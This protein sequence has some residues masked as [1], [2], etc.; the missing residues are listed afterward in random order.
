[1]K[2]RLEKKNRV[3]IDF[4]Q[5]ETEN[6]L[7][8]IRQGKIGKSG[9][10]NYTR[11][12]GSPENAIAELNIIKKEYLEKKFVE[13]AL[14]NKP[15]NFDGVYDKAKWHY[16]GDFPNHLDKFQASVHTGMY[17]TWLIDSELFDDHDLPKTKEEIQLV[18]ERKKTG[19]NF[20]NDQ[21]DGVLLDDDISEV[22]N[23]FSYFYYELE[24]GDY[25]N[26][27]TEI[28][29]ENSETLYHIE[30][31]WENYDKLKPVIDNRFRKWQNRQNKK[32]WHLFKSN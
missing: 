28:L 17:I 12:C 24:N 10:P 22:G 3:T 31:T 6:H 4:I 25:L 27:Y 18:K 26:D 16:G 8:R 9:G 14:K 5:L 20:Y 32:W 1:M 11:H 15:D 21:L 7:L 23:E 13:V 2:V 19:A 30:D 29:G